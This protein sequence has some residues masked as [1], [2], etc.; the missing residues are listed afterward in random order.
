MKESAPELN[1]SGSDA[2]DER[3][4]LKVEGESDPDFYQVISIPFVC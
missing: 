2:E 3:E 1:V 4:E